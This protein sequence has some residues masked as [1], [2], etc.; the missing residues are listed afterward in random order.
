[1][2]GIGIMMLL[3]TISLCATISAQK[4]SPESPDVEM[5][6]SVFGAS[7]I[8][9]IRQVGFSIHHSGGNPNDEI[10][11]DISIM[12]TIQSISDENIDFSYSKEI[13]SMAYN[14]GFQFLTNAITGSGAVELTVTASSSNA[15]ETS[16]TIHGFQIGSITLAQ[17]FF[18]SEL[19][20]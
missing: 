3:I 18:L 15:G 7:V 9:G 16:Q 13:E 17:P 6:V 10:I 4:Q 14:Q 20:Q 5:D 8:T 11:H 19:M 2:I 1:M 12:F